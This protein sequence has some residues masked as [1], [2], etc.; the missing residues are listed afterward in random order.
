M[1][2]LIAH[3]KIAHMRFLPM[4]RIHSQRKRRNGRIHEYSLSDDAVVQRDAV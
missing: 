4:S 1:I 3:N 2:N